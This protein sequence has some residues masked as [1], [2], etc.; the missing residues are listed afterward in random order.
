MPLVAPSDAPTVALLIGDDNM[1]AAIVFALES[2]SFHP[3]PIATST[4]PDSRACCLVIDWQ[5]K[6]RA[7]LL[8]VMRDW[9]G[10]AGTPVILLATAPSLELRETCRELGGEIFEKPLLG[11][12]LIA[13]I[14]ALAGLPEIDD[15][16]VSR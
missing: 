6:G 7:E 1:R 13:R 12:A 9:R 5:R 2:S 10:A 8:K 15:R 16:S 11:N 3:L 4:E 14:R